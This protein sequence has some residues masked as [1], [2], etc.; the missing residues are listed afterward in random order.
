VVVQELFQRAEATCGTLAGDRTELHFLQ[1]KCDI[2][3]VSLQ[4]R[5]AANLGV[6][7]AERLMERY[8]DCAREICFL[9]GQVIDRVLGR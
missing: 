9:S 7:S 1:G 5:V 6:G 2:L 3:S 8:S 4:D